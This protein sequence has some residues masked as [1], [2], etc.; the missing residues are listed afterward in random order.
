MFGMRNMKHEGIHVRCYHASKGVGKSP[1]YVYP[2]RHTDSC[3]LVCLGHDEAGEYMYAHRVCTLEH[4]MI[5]G[6]D[7]SKKSY[8]AE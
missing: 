1:R 8:T 2:R 3:P 5:T 7:G 6:N 4:T